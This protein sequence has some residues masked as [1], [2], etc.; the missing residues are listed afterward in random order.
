MYNRPAADFNIVF[1]LFAP[2]ILLL[3]LSS[4]ALVAQN[5]GQ[6][7]DGDLL[8]DIDPQEIEIRGKYQPSFAGLR[9]QPILGFDPEP[10]VYQ[11]DPNRQPFM[12]SGEDIMAD[13]PV[14]Q[15]DRP[16]PPSIKLMK[17]PDES[18]GLIRAALG[19]YLSPR[20]NGY[21]WTS[22]TGQSYVYGNINHH[23]TDGH[24]DVQPSSFRFLDGSATY[25][26]R[27][28]RD[29]EL[30]LKASGLSN[31]NHVFPA[32][33]SGGQFPDVTPRKKY[34]GFGIQGRFLERTTRFDGWNA[35]AGYNFFG[36]D[37]DAGP[38]TDESSE[39]VFNSSVSRQWTGSHQHEIFG[40]RLATD[41]GLYQPVSGRN[42]NW[43]TLEGRLYYDRL[44]GYSTRIKATLGVNYVSNMLYDSKFFATPWLSV[45]HWINDALRLKFTGGMDVGSPGLRDHHQ[46]N[47]LLR[48]NNVIAQSYNWLGTVQGEWHMIEGAV[49]RAGVKY[50]QSQHHPFYKRNYYPQSDVLNWYQIN[51]AENA[52]IW[53]PYAGFSYD[54]NPLKWRFDSKIYLNSTDISGYSSIPFEED[55]GAEVSATYRFLEQ[56]QLAGKL[57]VL[58]PRFD[59]DHNDDLNTAFLVGFSGKVNLSANWST[60]LEVENLLN[61]DYE[62]WDGYQER[63][64]EIYIGINYSF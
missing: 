24:L 34:S 64:L 28:D 15:L 56:V 19:H 10:R 4:S 63:D 9:R 30:Q 46:R 62:V 44:F 2:I 59:P 37:F 51:F 7:R 29:R 20:F 17:L 18:R 43:S 57:N 45:K 32:D 1:R 38:A 13:L 16:S 35:E 12:E 27:I 5:Q 61:Q 47:R 54:L 21:G 39:H 22:V 52:T 58:G 49:F 3:L 11:I 8:P 50:Q 60:F 6:S 42:G 33:T 53:Q 25:V 26:N 48:G 55:F 14:S 41:I 31:F 40:A 23:S 36:V